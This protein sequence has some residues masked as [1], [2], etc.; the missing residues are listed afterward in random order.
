MRKIRS[1]NKINLL[2]L[3]F[4]NPTCFATPSQPL[5]TQTNKHIH[6]VSHNMTQHDSSFILIFFF[7]YQIVGIS[8]NQHFIKKFHEKDNHTQYLLH[9]NII[10][11]LKGSL[12]IKFTFQLTN[13][14]FSLQALSSTSFTTFLQIKINFSRAAYH[15]P[16][17]PIEILAPHLKCSHIMPSQSSL[18]CTWNN[19]KGFIRLWRPIPVYHFQVI[20]SKTHSISAEE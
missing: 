17:F 9:K 13:S 10:V 1:Q 19:M 12:N 18:E 20:S 6:D 14:I 11:P 15:K 4:F 5:F 3:I 8:V 2:G 16:K 7:S